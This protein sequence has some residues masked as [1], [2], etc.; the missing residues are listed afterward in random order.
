MTHN[1]QHQV[2]QCYVRMPHNL[3]TFPLPS[4]P[5]STTKTRKSIKIKV[6]IKNQSLHFYIFF[7]FYIFTF[8]TSVII[9]FSLHFYIFLH[10]ITS[11]HFFQKSLTFCCLLIFIFNCCADSFAINLQQ[12]NS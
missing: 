11:L 1:P 9:F 7:I 10:F 2:L 3:G 4:P 8:F 5:F 6:E 12:M